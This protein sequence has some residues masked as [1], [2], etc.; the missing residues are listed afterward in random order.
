MLTKRS[1]EGKDYHILVRV[2]EVIDNGLPLVPGRYLPPPL[3]PPPP[4]CSPPSPL[5]PPSLQQEAMKVLNF[6]KSK[7]TM[8]IIL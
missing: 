5:L 1:P 3:L 2:T 8:I 6:R 7:Y 4:F